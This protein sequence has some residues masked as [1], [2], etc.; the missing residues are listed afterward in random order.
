MQSINSVGPSA[1]VGALNP[2]SPRYPAGPDAGAAAQ[3]AKKAS[4]PVTPAELRAAV[5]AANAALDQSSQ[6]FSFVFDDTSGGMQVKIIDRRT[7]TVVRLVPSEMMLAT[8]RRLSNATTTR[9]ALLTGE[10]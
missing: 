8:A 3:Q 10:A 9:G 4:T 1:V 2:Q 6:G 7:N 5:D